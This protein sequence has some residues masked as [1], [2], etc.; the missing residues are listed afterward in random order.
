MGT[1]PNDVFC[2]KAV[3]QDEV[4]PVFVLCVLR[5]GVWGADFMGEEKDV[6]TFFAVLRSMQ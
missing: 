6:E 3:S 5:Q 2:M 1:S 4:L